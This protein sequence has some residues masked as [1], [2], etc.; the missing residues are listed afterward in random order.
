MVSVEAGMVGCERAR[1][2]AVDDGVGPARRSEVRRPRPAGAKKGAHPK[3]TGRER[4]RVV[5]WRQAGT[6]KSRLDN[7]VVFTSTT[8]RAVAPLGA[9]G[10]WH[11]GLAQLAPKQIQPRGAEPGRWPTPGRRPR[12]TRR[13]T[14]PPRA[15]ERREGLL[16]LSPRSN[17]ENSSTIHHKKVRAPVRVWASATRFGEAPT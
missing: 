15:H 7:T 4:R 13:Q 3:V 12:S 1:S 14:A 5:F 9:R 17:L 2:E 16:A 10:P 6:T 11:N 8:S